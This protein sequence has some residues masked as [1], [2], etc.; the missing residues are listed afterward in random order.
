[1]IKSK[2]KIIAPII[3]LLIGAT[4]FFTNRYFKAKEISRKYELYY[5]FGNLIYKSESNFP[6]VF[7]GGKITHKLNDNKVVNNTYE[8]TGETVTLINSDDYIDSQKEL[9]KNSAYVIENQK[10][11]NIVF[12][13]VRDNNGNLNY[14]YN[15]ELEMYLFPIIEEESQHHNEGLPVGI[16]VV[17]P[18]LSDSIYLES[19]TAITA[20]Q[21]YSINSAD[22]NGLV[23]KKVKIKDVFKIPFAL[24]P[25]FGYFGDYNANRQIMVELLNFNQDWM[26]RLINCRDYDGIST[27]CELE[28]SGR[29]AKTQSGKLKLVVILD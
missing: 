26:D 6:Y 18:I 29:I 23:G 5:K 2:I 13:I 7:E 24:T 28:A 21:I 15:K 10:L 14:L 22:F 17:A 19:S 3:I 20:D 27:G 1:M 12:N 11:K 9:I 4:Y 16:G 25:G 8:I